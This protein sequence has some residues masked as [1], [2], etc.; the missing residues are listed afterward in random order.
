MELLAIQIRPKT[1]PTWYYLSLTRQGSR[2]RLD[3]RAYAKREAAEAEKA[4][5]ELYNSDVYDFRI[6]HL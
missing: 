4:A 6:A 5:L 1:H 2:R 3:A